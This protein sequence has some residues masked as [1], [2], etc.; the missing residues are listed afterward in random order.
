M[1][2]I[3]LAEAPPDS[4][5][6]DALHRELGARMVPFAGWEMAVQFAGLLEELGLQISRA[7]IAEAIGQMVRREI[8]HRAEQGANRYEF[9]VD[10]VRLWLEESKSLGLVAEERAAVQFFAKGAPVHHALDVAVRAARRI[11]RVHR[12]M[13]RAHDPERVN[14][15]VDPG[16]VPVPVPGIAP[17]AVVAAHQLDAQIQLNRCPPAALGQRVAHSAPVRDPTSLLQGAFEEGTGPVRIARV[18]C[19]ALPRHDGGLAASGSSQT[20]DQPKRP[21]M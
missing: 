2:A 19:E 6:L 12:P 9:T 5:P 1:Q 3:P 20:R 18:H 16:R 17:A 14:D 4:T 8:L 15:R 21:L 13:Q 10:L 11:A 7:G